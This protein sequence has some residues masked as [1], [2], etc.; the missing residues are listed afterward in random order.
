M[1]PTPLTASGGRFRLRDLLPFGPRRHPRPRPFLE[2]LR[3]AWE[4]RDNLGYAWRILHHGVCDGCSLGPRGLARRRDRRRPPLH[5][6]AQA[7]PAEHHGADPGRA[8]SR[9]VA[10]ARAPCAT[11]SC[12]ALGRL[13]Y[14]MIH[15]ARRATG[16]T[17]CRGTRRSRIVAE[18]LRDVA[19]RAH[20]LL[21]HLA[22]HRQRD[23]LR[24]P[25]GRAAAGLEPRRPVRAPL[26][27]GERAR[28]SRTPSAS[29]PRPARS[30]T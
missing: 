18:E 26:P 14:P 6:A 23:L 16:S 10:G 28:A 5:D 30:R 22:R 9:D 20:G 17:G 21:R 11:T 25:E 19:R 13:P 3:I 29:R 1:S 27:R 8:R 2:M 12:T 4:N 15:R 24:L 7:A